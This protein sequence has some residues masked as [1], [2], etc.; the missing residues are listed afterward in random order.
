MHEHD[1]C[2]DLRLK[3]IYACDSEARTIWRRARPD[4]PAGRHGHGD[5]PWP[6]AGVSVTVSDI[7]DIQV[8]FGPANWDSESNSELS[9]AVDGQRQP[10][11]GLRLP[12]K[13]WIQQIYIF[14]NLMIEWRLGRFG[15]G[16]EHHHFVQTNL[17]LW[18]T[19][20]WQVAMPFILFFSVTEYILLCK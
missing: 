6:V 7:I 18:G 12:P 16:R 11:P 9:S 8:K 17:N 3:T 10:E 19:T 20:L 4:R 13:P 2:R 14:V 15:L 1:K 5:C